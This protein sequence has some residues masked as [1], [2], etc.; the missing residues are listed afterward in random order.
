VVKCDFE[1]ENLEQKAAIAS[2]SEQLSRASSLTRGL[3]GV[4]ERQAVIQHAVGEAPLVVVPGQ[5]LQQFAADLVWLASKIDDS[6]L[7]L[8][9]LETSGRCCNPGF[10]SAGWRL[11]SAR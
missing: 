11:S 3:F 4:A 9:S 10:S 8:K 6:G 7:W 1:Q 5:H 2:T